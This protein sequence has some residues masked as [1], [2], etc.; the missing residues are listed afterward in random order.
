MKMLPSI[1]RDAFANGA[2]KSKLLS[3][4]AKNPYAQY[5]RYVAPSYNA[6]AS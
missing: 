4:A 5:S 2:L 3:K 1:P 6:P